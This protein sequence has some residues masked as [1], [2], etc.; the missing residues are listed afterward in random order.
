M[1]VFVPWHSKFSD[2]CGN[3]VAQLVVMMPNQVDLVD[4]AFRW[5]RHLPSGLPDCIRKNE[6]I[7][8]FLTEFG[9]GYPAEQLGLGESVFAKLP[10]NHR[11]AAKLI[12]Q[13]LAQGIFDADGSVIPSC[14]HHA[15]L[16]I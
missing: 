6:V 16:H 3:V 12:A 2:I 1:H 5:F 15:N 10:D 11:E 14:M 7:I 8:S 9:V 13:V 4:G